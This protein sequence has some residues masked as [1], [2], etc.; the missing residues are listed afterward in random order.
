MKNNSGLRGFEVDV[1]SSHT[2]T[3]RDRL[4]TLSC[5]FQRAGPRKLNSDMQ[6]MVRQRLSTHAFPREYRIHYRTA[7]DADLAISSVSFCAAGRK[8]QCDDR[9]GVARRRQID[10]R[11]TYW[12]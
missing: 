4:K 10:R 1:T 11:S 6:Q 9:R 5:E 8:L 7:E 3:Y 12:E 2:R